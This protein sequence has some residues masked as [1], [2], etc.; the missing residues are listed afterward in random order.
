MTGPSQSHDDGRPGT[1]GAPLAE[2]PPTAFGHSGR[3]L[4]LEVAI[5]IGAVIIGGWA[6]IQ[7]GRSLAGALAAKLPYDVDRALGALASDSVLGGARVCTNPRLVGAVTA[8][9][10]HLEVR[11][12]PVYHPL[13]V[14]VVEDETVNAFALPGGHVFVMTG[15]L[16]AVESP[17]ELAGVLGHEI[18]HVV[19]RHGIQR[20]AQ[21][22]WVGFLLSWVTGGGLAED[23][24]SQG[25]ALLTLKFGRDQELESDSIGLDLMARAGY[26]PTRFPDFFARLGDAGLPAF[27]S[28]H[29]DP[30]DRVAE[31]RKVA[32]G[33]R[34]ER[35]Q[36]GV[37]S[38]EDL[39]APCE[40][41]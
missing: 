23:L 34:P 14:R 5:A 9:V 6:I 7:G 37:P 19:Q 21:S 25:A 27:L 8:V 1:T 24:T 17:D 12:D 20:I 22:M 40:G 38:L 30:G 28:T 26:D 33:M 31:L 18:A 41:P 11:L 4:W 15:L 3:R 29:P 39:R 32:G 16:R 35:P 10:S 36:V 13:T 2:P